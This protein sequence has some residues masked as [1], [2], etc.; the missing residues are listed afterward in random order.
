MSD[1]HA[2]SLAFD[3]RRSRSV[4]LPALLFSVAVHAAAGSLLFNGWLRLPVEPP[5]PLTVLLEAVAP[6]PVF[7]I[8]Q[9]RL[10]HKPVKLAPGNSVLPALSVHHAPVPSPLTVERFEAA[11]A[12]TTVPVSTPAPTAVA[13]ARATVS[14]SGR[15]DAIEPPHFNVAYL[16]NPRPTY[17]PIARRLGLEGLVVLRVQVSAKGAPE[18]VAVAQTSGASV[19]DEAALKAVQGWT[20]T[21]ARRGDTPVAHMVDVPIR[22]Q[23]KN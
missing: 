5:H 7:E 3:R 13:N 22:F 20:F 18:Q 12:V 23:L 10:A 1:W 6:Q 14:S 16:N 9:P 17:P 2:S 4:L 19:L 15:A 8:P 21:P 11:P